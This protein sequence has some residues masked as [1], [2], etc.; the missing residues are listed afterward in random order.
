[1]PSFRELLTATKREITEITTATASEW[2]AGRSPVVLDV[3]EPDEYEQ[4]AL[5]DAIHIPRGHLEAQIENRLPDHDAEIIVYCAGGVRSAFAAKTLAELGYPNAVSMDGGFGQWK[6]EG[7]PWSTPA[8][9][10][11]EQRNRYQ[12]HLLLPEVGEA[13]QLKLLDAR[14]LMLGAGGLG[15][16]A[17]LYLAAAGVGTLGIIDMDVVDESNL[18]RQILH[19]V[20]RVGDRKVDSAKK[21]LTA[22][23]PD[24]NVVTYDTR[25]G[26]DNVLEILS[27]WDVIVD[28]ADN[29]PSR[30]L[31][32]DAS[33][34]L[35]IPVVHGSIFRFE[36]QV[37]V[38]DPQHGPT[39]RD[40]LPEPP[41]AELAPSC[42]EAGV[43]GVLPG[44]VGSIQALET[45]KLILGVGDS[46][47][48]R[49]IAFDSLEMTFREFRLR[50]DP[51]NEVT[52]DNRE[53]IAV[54]EL[55]GLCSPTLN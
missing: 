29:F 4:G 51:A 26:A 30:Y 20:D 46:L 38:F 35:G 37:T 9:L 33:V 12:R 14:V 16:P 13:G 28:G 5:A 10:G 3:R 8:S 41:P 36:G 47:S 21:T 11:A 24:V 27:G 44:I 32:N 49:I 25:L 1:M 45:I 2:I 52:Y 48:G 50:P 55:D 54:S 18:Q 7:R 34:K 42:A 39:Y 19:N 31:L 53:R 22:L 23:N 43:L 40:Y 6:D 15:S 17:A